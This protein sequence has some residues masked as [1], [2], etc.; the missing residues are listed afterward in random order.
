MDYSC[1]LLR[2]LSLKGMEDDIDRLIIAAV[3]AGISVL[4]RG[5]FS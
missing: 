4:L 2:D 1:S 3:T 5:M